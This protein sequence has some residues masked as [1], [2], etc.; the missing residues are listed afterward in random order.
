MRALILSTLLGLAAATQLAGCVPVVAVGMG[1]GV[2]MAEDRRTASTYLMDEEIELKANS[3][4]REAL[5][6]GVHINVT[7]YNRRILLTGEAADA[8]ARA[9]AA[10]VAKEV[11]NVRDVYNEIQAAG[12]S[13][14]MSRTNDAYITT[15]VKAR[16]FDDRRFSGH[17]VKVVTEAGV[18]YLMGLVKRDEGQA[19]AE[20]AAKTSGVAKVVKVFEYL[21]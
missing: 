1:T 16:L 9:K 6:E 4:I 12:V 8:G 18:V 14:I 13:T 15:K 3:Q 10:Q 11:P 17:H 7:S 5:K 19:A 21:D 2:M 20:I